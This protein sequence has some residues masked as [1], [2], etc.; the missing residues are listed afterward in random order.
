MLTLWA[1]DVDE[2][3]E[4][5]RPP[6]PIKIEDMR[7][8]RKDGNIVG[9]CGNW[10]QFVKM[11]GSVYGEYVDFITPI[12][13]FGEKADFLEILRNGIPADR[14]VLVGNIKG[15]TGSSDE[16]GAAEKT[17]WEFIVEHEFAGGKR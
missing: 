3:L 9:I 11:V 17:G 15:V 1:F 14:Y 8:L 6:G 2:T 5:G 13:Y 16:K 4:V 12:G 7:T 10:K